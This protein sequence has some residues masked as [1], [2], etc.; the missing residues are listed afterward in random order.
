MLSTHVNLYARVFYYIQFIYT[1][2]GLKWTQTRQAFSFCLQSRR[3]T[4]KTKL[5]CSCKLYIG[6]PKEV[7]CPDHLSISLSSSYCGYAKHSYFINSA[8]KIFV[9][10]ICLTLISFDILSASTLYC[11]C[12][13][14]TAKFKQGTDN[15]HNTFRTV[16]ILK[17]RNEIA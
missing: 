13:K 15:K 4:V 9:I 12:S 2:I 7:L 3:T 8:P 5:K 16:I 1:F 6:Y 17:I 10:L 11:E 14:P